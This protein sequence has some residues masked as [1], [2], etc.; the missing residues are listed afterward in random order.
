MGC[1]FSASSGPSKR[2]ALKLAKRQGIHQLKQNYD[3]NV[4]SKVLGQGTFGK[5]FLTNHKNIANHQV[6]VKVLNKEK[7]KGELD[8]IREEV[9]ILNNLDHPNI[10]KYHET[11]EDPK[12][13][14]IVMEYI[15]GGELFDLI[16]KQKNSY[17]TEAVA[18]GYFKTLLEALLHM[19]SSGIVHRD[20]KPENIMVSDD[21]ELKFI[22]FGLARRALIKKKKMQTYAG[23]PAYMA[24]E[25][26]Q[27]ID[28][29]SNVD[30]WS[31]GVLLYTLLSGYLPFQGSIAESNEKICKG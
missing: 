20:I 13:M 10:V 14:Y 22:D 17:F 3:I 11:Y 19:H 25:I 27:G 30:L 4:T 23:T 16:V 9:A 31:M 5:V 7:L 28:Y 18:K 21:G 29:D 26:I 2:I 24:P 15:S 12:F 6:A 8:F 1:C